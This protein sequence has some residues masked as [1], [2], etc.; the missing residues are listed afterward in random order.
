VVYKKNPVGSKG[1]KRYENSGL[2]FFVVSQIM[3]FKQY[4]FY[5][6]NNS[7]VLHGILEYKK[8]IR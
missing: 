1:V 5:Y 8:D 6:Q 7:S 2:G 4:N 3:F